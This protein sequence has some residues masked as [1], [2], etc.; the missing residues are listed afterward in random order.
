MEPVPAVYPRRTFSDRGPPANAAAG[1]GDRGKDITFELLGGK[2]I[3]PG[4]Y[5]REDGHLRIGLIGMLVGLLWVSRAAALDPDSLDWRVGGFVD[6][7]RYQLDDTD[8]TGELQNFMGA[9][10][11]LD[12]KIDE[13]WSMNSDLLW[14]FWRQKLHAT[15]LFHVKSIR[16]DADMRGSLNYASGLQEARFGIYDFKYNP[17][18][19]DLGEYLLRSTAYPTIIESAQG[20]DKL[21]YSFNRVLGAEYGLAL[22]N[23]RTKALVYAEQ[24]RVPVNDVT[25]ALFA[26]VGPKHAELEAG[27]AFDR[28]WRFG[29]Q[30]V[31]RWTPE[32]S[33]Y[34]LSQGLKETSLQLNTKLTLRGRLDFPAMF[35]SSPKVLP[36]VYA[37]GA[38]LGLKNDSLYY[39]KMTERMPVM[40]GIDIPTGPVLDVFSVEV[41]YWKNP[42]HD[43]KYS[44]ADVDKSKAS[45]LPYILA[46][47]QTPFKRDDWR[48]SVFL[49]RALNNW[50]DVETRIASDHQR[51]YLFTGDYITGVPMTELSKDWY[52]LAR[53]SY[54]N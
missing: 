5:R 3:D 31:K 30:Q 21:A 32:D 48:W 34:I 7:G 50:I 18:S 2:G 12:Y 44:I 53:V 47:D 41:E 8:A 14:L 51:L 13:H 36:I 35:E 17:D 46:S 23:F 6:A 38:L 28:Y 22:P 24:F 49:K 15:A 1:L 33:A 29:K 19:K 9:T 27:V 20:K 39:K 26:A 10:W 40:L 16:F 43:R 37:E 4:R 54:H 45:P 42:Y 52:F 11:K 25:P